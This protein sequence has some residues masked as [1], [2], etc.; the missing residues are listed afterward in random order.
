M[1]EKVKVIKI[2]TSL[3]ERILLE[4]AEESESPTPHPYEII[5]EFAHQYETLI[6]PFLLQGDLQAAKGAMMDSWARSSG[7]GTGRIF[8]Q[9]GFRAYYAYTHATKYLEIMARTELS[10]KAL[11][12]YKHMVDRM[13]SEIDLL[14]QGDERYE[15]N[16][17]REEAKNGM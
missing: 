6:R 11:N 9:K 4:E 2:D 15:K 1:E 17:K 7:V 13:V 16:R 12:E 5:G 14:L 8:H 10:E 3:L